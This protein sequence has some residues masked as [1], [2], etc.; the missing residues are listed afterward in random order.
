MSDLTKYI[1]RNR[2]D[3]HL[4]DRAR[5]LFQ[6]YEGSNV[7]R[8]GLPF[9]ENVKITE[10]KKSRIATYNPIGRSSS[11]FAYLGAEARNIKLD[12]NITVPHLVQNYLD[13]QKR[14][15]ALT[16]KES[17]LDYLN[18]VD[19]P[20]VK[21]PV[22]DVIDN[23]YATLS[24]PEEGAWNRVS[25]PS[26]GVPD[27]GPTGSMETKH[28]NRRKAHAAVL[29]FIN[30]IRSSVVNNSERPY[31]GPPL[32]L[33]DYGIQYVNVPLLAR[34]YSI[35]FSDDKGYDTELLLP[36]VLEVSLD[37]VEVRTSGSDD[38]SIDYFRNTGWEKTVQDLQQGN[39]PGV[40][41]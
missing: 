28:S 24:A 11:L 33:L 3:P 4:Q 2:V 31:D 6:F 9:F 27:G 22:R 7:I 23:F 15:G 19:P 21:S 16:S 10:R 1:Y 18:S 38:V 39:N 32:L 34:D 17:K 37:L 36:R 40:I 30:L 8:I 13:T 12:F 20:S 25:K 14:T 5:L 29:E 26:V 41:R 35:K